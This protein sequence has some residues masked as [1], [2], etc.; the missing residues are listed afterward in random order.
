M[1]GKKQF[2]LG[3]GPGGGERRNR[4]KNF[5]FVALLILFGMVIFAAFN[6][7][8]QLKE[9]PFS[10]VIN[11]ANAGNLQKIQVD[12]NQLLI[13]PKGESKPTGKSFKE[14]G[15]SIYQQGLQQGK[16]EIVNKPSSSGGSLCIFYT[17]PLV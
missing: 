16:V 5:G 8:T 13:T 11:D 4:F 12:G 3:G 15:A 2:R 10:Q 9:I 1:G 14:E 7:P 6:Q 17:A